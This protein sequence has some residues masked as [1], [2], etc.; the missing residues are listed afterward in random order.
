M[1]NIEPMNNIKNNIQNNMKLNN[2]EIEAII[3]TIIDCAVVVKRSLGVGYL[4]MVYLNALMVE[5][6]SKGLKVEKEKPIEV[7]YRGICVGYYRVD[8]LVNDSVI[9]ELKVAEAIDKS[10]EMQLV[11]YL[12]TT[13]IDNGLII[14][15]GSERIEVKRKYRLF[16]RQ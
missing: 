4:E 15:F 16:Q 12:Q 3:K 7:Y 13:G 10:H 8:I 14:N 11:N 2:Q 9:I 6:S 1:N 5:M